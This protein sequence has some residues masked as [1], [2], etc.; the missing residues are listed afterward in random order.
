MDCWHICKWWS[1]YRPCVVFI[2]SPLHIITLMHWWWYM[3]EFMSARAY[4]YDRRSCWDRYNSYYTGIVRFVYS[5][6]TYTN[7]E[8][9]DYSYNQSYGKTSPIKDIL[10]TLIGRNP[11]RSETGTKWRKK[12][13]FMLYYYVKEGRRYILT[14]GTIPAAGIPGSRDPPGS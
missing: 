12:K 2:F 8:I 9:V 3:Y 5:S 4:K 10:D 1:I 13:N 14:T 11:P 7:P 6:Y